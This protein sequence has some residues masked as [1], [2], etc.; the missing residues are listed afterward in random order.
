MTYHAVSVDN[1][2]SQI[3][4]IRKEPFNRLRNV[5]LENIPEGFQETISYGMPSYVVPLSVYSAGYHCKPE[6]PLPFLSI[7]SQKHFIGYYNMGLCAMPQLA[8]WFKTA[9]KELGIGRLDMG[10]SCVRLKKIDAIPYDLLGELSSKVSINEWIEVYEQ[11]IKP[12]NR[13]NP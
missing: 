2:C 11:S 3:P 8:D 7:A 6:E 10:K 5:I 13:R 9:W 12:A 1:Y 4:E